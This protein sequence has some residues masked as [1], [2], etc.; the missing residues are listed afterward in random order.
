MNSSWNL[1]YEEI[2]S[3]LIHDGFQPQV[4]NVGLPYVPSLFLKLLPLQD[5]KVSE[6][7]KSEPVPEKNNE[8][9]KTVVLDTFDEMVLNS[10]KNGMY[11]R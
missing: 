10:G 7:Y 5:G 11:S 3:L 8:P 4:P 2:S 6:F 9:I 1:V